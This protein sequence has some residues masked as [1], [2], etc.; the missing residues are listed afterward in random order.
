MSNRFLRKNGLEKPTLEYMYSFSRVYALKSKIRQYNQC[1]ES[2]R[3]QDMIVNEK[4]KL[5]SMSE[6]SESNKNIED[7]NNLCNNSVN[8]DSNEF[9]QLKRVNNQKNESMCEFTSDKVLQNASMASDSYDHIQSNISS[10]HTSK[11][12]RSSNIILNNN[13]VEKNNPVN[14]QFFQSPLKSGETIFDKTN[15]HVQFHSRSEYTSETIHHI[16]STQSNSSVTIRNKKRKLDTHN[17]PSDILCLDDVILVNAE[18][19]T[20]LDVNDLNDCF[21]QND[22]ARNQNNSPLLPEMSDSELMQ[23]LDELTDGILYTPDSDIYS[24]TNNT[25]VE[26]IN[27]PNIYN[28]YSQNESINHISQNNLDQS[29][30][31]AEKNQI[32]SSK[33]PSTSNNL[34]FDFNNCFDESSSSYEENIQYDESNDIDKN[35]SNSSESREFNIE[36][37]CKKFN[38]FNKSISMIHSSWMKI[39]KP[40][41]STRY[42]QKT[43]LFLQSLIDKKIG[44]SPQPEKIFKWAEYC[45]LDDVKVVILGVSPFG[46]NEIDSGLAFS[47]NPS[48]FE[49]LRFFMMS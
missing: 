10:I 1:D 12:T 7:D 23:I 38:F 32:N 8:N 26:L 16:S 40:I 41:F 4:H 49:T 42:F 24:S 22:I 28:S 2:V 18:N 36:A 34:S 19:L 6:V 30:S 25:D 21:S 11:N 9:Q 13:S 33:S 3:L 43:L 15:Q 27:K 20:T 45:K 5:H 31:Y 44:F 39:L 46:L 48:K 29:L 17:E 47:I 35:K 37:F 14:T